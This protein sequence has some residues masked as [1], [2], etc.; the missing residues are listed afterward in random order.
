MYTRFKTNYSRNDKNNTILKHTTV[1]NDC[2]FSDE[3]MLSQ[4]FKFF[5]VILVVDFSAWSDKTLRKQT[6]EMKFAKWD[7]S[8]L[9]NG[10]NGLESSFSM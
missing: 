3:I 5:S 6:V 9:E 2:V 7:Y 8:I 4:V 1:I 10:K